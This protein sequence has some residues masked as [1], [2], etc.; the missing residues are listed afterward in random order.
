MSSSL[1]IRQVGNLKRLRP[2]VGD[3]QSIFNFMVVHIL[4]PRWSYLLT[5]NDI[6]LFY[7]YPLYVSFRFYKY[8]IIN[9]Y[10][11]PKL[12][13]RKFNILVFFLKY[14]MKFDILKK[15]FYFR[16]KF[17]LD[18]FFKNNFFFNWRSKNFLL[19]RKYKNKNSSLPFFLKK[20]GRKYKNKYLFLSSNFFSLLKI[21][22]K[23]TFTS[24]ISQI[25]SSLTFLLKNLFVKFGK[26]SNLK[27]VIGFKSCL[28]LESFGLVKVLLLVFNRSLNVN[29]N[30][31]NFYYLQLLNKIC[32]NCKIFTEIL[33][34]FRGYLKVY[35]GVEKKYKNDFKRFLRIKYMDIKYRL[36]RVIKKDY[37][38]FIQNNLEE[39]FSLV[40]FVWVKSSKNMKKYSSK[41]SQKH[42]LW[43]L[44]QSYARQFS[45][46]NKSYFKDLYKKIFKKYQ[47]LCQIKFNIYVEKKSLLFQKFP[48]F[49]KNLELKSN[50]IKLITPIKLPKNY[51][52]KDW[53]SKFKNNEYFKSVVF[54]KFFFKPFYF[55]LIYF[56]NIFFFKYL[57]ILFNLWLRFFFKLNNFFNVKKLFNF[58]CLNLK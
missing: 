16:F 31:Y 11:K 17:L 33:G 5:L 27:K 9:R 37:Y 35:K 3:F 49:V 18:Y 42:F 38:S 4:I 39:L 44:W 30:W 43:R 28:D 10:I 56:F 47:I 26:L 45:F 19:S 23:V 15:I 34:N 14:N 1:I 2:W 46:G 48:N 8:R 12:L 55:W 36:K 25:K 20:N 22:S 52:K 29:K 40:K 58:I 51:V 13:V 6:G 21:N 54:W 57:K 32:K 7:H 50:K 24:W 53:K 41:Y